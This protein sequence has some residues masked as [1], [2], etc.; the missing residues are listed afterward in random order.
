MP[1]SVPADLRQS[2]LRIGSDA[3]QV[4]LPHGVGVVRHPSVDVAE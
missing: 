4:A 1:E 2:N 3:V